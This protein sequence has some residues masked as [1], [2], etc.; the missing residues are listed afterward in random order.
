MW[1]RLLQ[2]AAMCLLMSATTRV[3]AQQKY[4]LLLKGGRLIDARNTINAVRDVAIADGK[5]AAVAASL[6]LSEPVRSE[7]GI[8]RIFSA[9]MILAIALV[10]CAGS[11]RRYQR[12]RYTQTR[13]GGM[14]IQ[15]RSEAS[16]DTPGSDF[17][18]GGATE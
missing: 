12:L 6:A 9:A 5:V 15:M 11:A 13:A 17:G 3:S 7:P 18:I 4:D 10:R 8:T 2:A 14:F 1:S 16:V